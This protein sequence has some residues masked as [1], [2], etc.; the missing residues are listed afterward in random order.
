MKTSV[1]FYFQVH[2]PYR[3]Q[4]YSY[5]DIGGERNYF[6]DPENRRIM[7]RVAERCYVPMNRL[8]LEA[9]EETDGAFRCA[10]AVTGTA[11]SQM[12]AW[13]PEA[14]QS[15]VD[16]AHT[17]CVEFVCETAFHSLASHG[18]PL[19]FERQVTSQRDRLERLFGQR[20]RSFRN[21]ELIFDNDV[22]KRIEDL[23]FDVLLGEGADQLME[24]RSPRRVFRPAGCD[25]LRL[26]L[27]DYLFS[28]D[29][30]FRFSNR[31][32]EQY[33]LMAD[34]FCEWLHKAKPDD[35]VI[36][37]FMDYETF[38]E[39]QGP[40]TGI[41]DFM[42]HVPRFLL[43]DPRFDFATPAELVERV[44][45][46]E[47]ISCPTPISWA[48]AE[49]DLSAWLRNPMQL[50]AHKAL[51]DLLP[52]VLRADRLPP[53]AP[54][55]P[56][57]RGEPAT[58]ESASASKA[59]KPA[60]GRKTKRAGSRKTK[61]AKRAS[62]GAALL[63]AEAAPS[64]TEHTAPAEPPLAAGLY[65]IWQR[66]TTS[67]HVYYMSTKFLSDGDVHEYFTPYESPHDSYVVFMNVLDDL[68]RRVRARL[69]ASPHPHRTTPEDSLG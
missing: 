12:E 3:L 17:G 49:R 32:W 21:T 18:D 28:D 20:P 53:P 13:A 24:G 5:F 19:E 38:G 34:T 1:V 56:H 14:L 37:L 47:T 61:R 62:S 67:D 30:A 44:A 63:S 68:S 33:P 10:F 11:L 43:E 48:D 7:E 23:G 51:Y 35:S 52:D 50:A 60:K 59:S 69:T 41:F 39:H 16:L 42:R 31:E 40:D 29:I 6:N 9:I 2:Q 4:R 36:G 65:D 26:L 66:L 64:T 8:L 46:S 27:R 55:V 25:H 22:A 15:F 54:R 57:G 58:S 45:P